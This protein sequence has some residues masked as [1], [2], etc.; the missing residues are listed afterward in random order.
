MGTYRDVAETRDLAPGKGMPVEVGGHKIALFNIDGTYCAI[1]ATCTHRGGPLA[2]GKLDG[3][4][5][6]C[7]WHGARF[8]V[9]SGKN[10]TPPAPQEVPC[11]AVRIQGKE[12]QV[13]IP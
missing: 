8:D 5:V 6:V 1:G 10:L 9:R 3:A 13:E 11:Y 12:I 2:E 7:P 4:V